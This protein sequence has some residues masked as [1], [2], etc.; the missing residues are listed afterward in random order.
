MADK[1]EV[2]KSP[3]QE[4]EDEYKKE[5]KHL[6]KSFVRCANQAKDVLEQSPELRKAVEKKDRAAVYSEVAKVA[7]GIWAK[8]DVVAEA[9]QDIQKALVSQQK[10]KAMSIVK[11]FFQ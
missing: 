4:K 9:V 6:I 2:K 1:N 5:V 7:V 3:E 10:D 11:S 8:E